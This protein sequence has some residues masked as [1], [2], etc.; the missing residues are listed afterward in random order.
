MQTYKPSEVPFYVI[1][2]DGDS[3]FCHDSTFTNVQE[4]DDVAFGD[5]PMIALSNF[6]SKRAVEED[7]KAALAKQPKSGGET[8][9][10]SE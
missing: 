5:S 3:W 1:E 8:N 4:S 2:S 7:R 6:L 10:D 9:G